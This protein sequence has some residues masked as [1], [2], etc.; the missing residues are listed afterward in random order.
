MAIPQTSALLNKSRL[1]LG[2][3]IHPFKDLT[4]CIGFWNFLDI[5]EEKCLNAQIWVFFLSIFVFFF[6]KNENQIIYK[7]WT[8]QFEDLIFNLIKEC[9]FEN[10]YISLSHKLQILLFSSEFIFSYFTESVLYLLVGKTFV[11]YW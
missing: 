7:I 4:V 9:N 3:I 2:V 6:S 5:A 10:I 1:P 11:F 8:L